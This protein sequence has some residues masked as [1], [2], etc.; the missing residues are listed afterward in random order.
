MAK[1][2]T[3]YFVEQGKLKHGDKYKYDSSDYNGKDKP[4]NI[5][6]SI[7]GEVELPTAKSHFV[8]S[9]CFKCDE[10][11][12]KKK[13]Q[14]GKY[15]KNKGSNYELK[16]MHELQELGFPD[17]VTSRSESKRFDAKKVDLIDPTGKL[18]FYPQIKCTLN[19]PDYFGIKEKSGLTDKEFVLFW[20]RQVVKK[21]QIDMS[22]LGEI[23]MLTKEY[24][25]KLL[26]NKD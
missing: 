24:F 10:E 13:R 15:S 4:I 9:G 16:I 20:N 18:P 8:R 1:W 2:T 14:S 23:V 17:V 5:I 25:Y 22:S 11:K 21:G 6:C 12:A 3:E 19:T 26:K 7:H